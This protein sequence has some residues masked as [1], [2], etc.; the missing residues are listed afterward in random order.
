MEASI[1][2]DRA[3]LYCRPPDKI[4]SRH[5][6]AKKMFA[7]TIFIS[8]FNSRSN[9]NLYQSLHIVVWKKFQIADKVCHILTSAKW[10]N[11]T[12]DD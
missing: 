10:Q 5:T 11:I 9:S 4:S 12:R 1:Q 6:K 2:L 3:R 8:R 7:K